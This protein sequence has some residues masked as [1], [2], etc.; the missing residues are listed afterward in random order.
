[1]YYIYLMYSE[2]GDIKQWKVGLSI[3]PDRRFK[4]LKC[5]NPNLK[6]IAVQY[7][8][9]DRKLAYKTEALLK[10]FLKPFTIN[11]EWVEYIA[12]NQTLFIEYCN[13]YYNMAKSIVENTNNLKT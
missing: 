12:L 9:S 4:Q 5:G 2:T 11:G 8:I 3:H 6:H 13:K 10:R 7:E 1:M